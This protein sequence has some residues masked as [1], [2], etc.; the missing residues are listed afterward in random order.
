MIT[1]KFTNRFLLAVTLFG[2]P[3]LFAAGQD[4]ASAYELAVADYI[5][6]A[7]RQLRAIRGEVDAA[8][9]K[10]G[11]AGKRA[12]AEVY[13]GLDLCDATV[14]QL[15]VAVPRD[16]DLIKMRF[17]N[18]RAQTISGLENVRKASLVAAPAQPSA[19]KN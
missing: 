2:A 16:F 12:Y 17:E 7:T 9:A 5:D 4:Q 3:A 15:R 8:V 1:M 6:G 13:R 10:A 14:A 11:D 19:M 18:T